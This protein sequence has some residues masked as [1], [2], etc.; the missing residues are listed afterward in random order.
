MTLAHPRVRFASRS[1]GVSA[2]FV[3]RT[4][5][6]ALDGLEEDGAG[7]L[8]CGKSD[9]VKNDIMQAASPAVSSTQVFA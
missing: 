3:Y 6:K 1:S 7:E 5:A 2:K 9:E 4:H 8:L